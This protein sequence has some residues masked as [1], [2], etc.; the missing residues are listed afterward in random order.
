LAKNTHFVSMKAI[1]RSNLRTVEIMGISIHH[2][3][4]AD[5][6][7]LTDEMIASSKLHQIATANPEFLMKAQADS[8]FFNLL[9]NVDLC[10]AD[11]NG[12]VWA[13]R[14]LHDPLP[15]RVPGSDLVYYLAQ[16]C[17]EKG[18]RLFLLGAAPGVA[19]KAA[20][21]LQTFYEGLKIAGTYAGSPAPEENDYI[22]DLINESQADVL[23]VAYG[24]PKQDKWIARNKDKL[25][26]VRVAVGVGGSIDF[27]AGKVKRAPKWV[28]DISLEWLY[29]VLV[30]PSRWRRVLYIPTFVVLILFKYKKKNALPKT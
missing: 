14:Q 28:Q 29:R 22:V 11:G 6:L 10:V 26:T 24:A 9:N 18:W 30:Q 20:E 2:V 27:I 8:E 15:E 17:A 5:T 1:S 13:S 19:E 3:T 23:Y 16:R 7:A 12:L 4:M 21:T 25:T